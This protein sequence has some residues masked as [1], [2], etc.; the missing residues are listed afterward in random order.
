[1]G[2][3]LNSRHPMFLYWGP[4][5]VQLYNDAYLPTFGASAGEGKHPAA[6]GQRGKDCWPELWHL[7]GPQIDDVMSRAKASWHED[8]L[9]PVWRNG[10][11]EESY[12]TYGYSPIFCEDGTVGGTLVVCNET[13][14]RVIAA[15]RQGTMRAL[16]KATA[17]ATTVSAVLAAASQLLEETPNDSPFALIYEV[18]EASGDPVVSRAAGLRD[19]ERVAVDTACRP[20]LAAVA[21]RGSIDR[22]SCSASA[23]DAPSTPLTASTSCSSPSTLGWRLPV[24]RPTGPGRRRRRSETTCSGSWKRR[25]EPRT[26]FWPCSATSY[27]TRSRRS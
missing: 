24:A 19:A 11:V 27:E 13:T 14:A 6:M 17:P 1:V 25:T 15:Q 26:S 23:P 21:G 12:W 18:D 9:V 16:A 2:M 4:E 22:S 10:R 5:L 3:M 8:Q 20:K 7:I